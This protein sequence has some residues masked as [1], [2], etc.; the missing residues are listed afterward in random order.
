MRTMAVDPDLVLRL[1]LAT[2]IGAA[3]GLNRNSHG[4]P[5]GLRTH[6]LVA[7]GSALIVLI[8]GQ[9]TG[10]EGS[11]A[12]DAQSRV[13]QGLITGIGF[14]GAGVILHS[15]DEKRVHGLTTA[16]AIWVAAL[17]GAA[18]GAGMFGP[19]FVAFVLLVLILV[20]GGPVEKA[21]HRRLKAR[22]EP[23]LK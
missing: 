14:L 19:V 11:H 13:I 12:A 23:T 10:A 5:A 20:I 3:I 21:I 6:A 17:F 18:C 16:A 8:S 15:I 2:L 7:L 1:S 22:D 4:K 9:L